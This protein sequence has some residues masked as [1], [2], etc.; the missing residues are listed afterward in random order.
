MTWYIYDTDRIY[1]ALRTVLAHMCHVSVWIN[2]AWRIIQ[3]QNTKTVILIKNWMIWSKMQIWM[4]KSFQEQK[5]KCVFYVFPSPPVS[6]VSLS[7]NSHRDFQSFHTYVTSGGCG[8]L[9]YAELLPAL[10]T[11]VCSYFTFGL[12]LFCFFLNL[13]IWPTFLS[14]CQTSSCYLSSLLPSYAKLFS[15]LLS[16]PRRRFCITLNI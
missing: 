16:T 14:L 8:R 7:F 5:K 11:S 15:F 3:T 1:L 12:W 9:S 6:D 4:D 10:A 2:M 13:L